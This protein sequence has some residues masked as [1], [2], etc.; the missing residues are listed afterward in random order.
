MM[1]PAKD[2]EE[3]L[4]GVIRWEQYSPEHKCEL[5]SH[6]V[7]HER[8]LWIFDP[9]PLAPLRVR[10]LLLRSNRLRIL[11]TN[12]NH[13]RDTVAWMKLPATLQP[14]ADRPTVTFGPWKPIPL[15]GGAPGETAFFLEEASLLVLGDAVVNLPKRKL[16]ILPDKYCTDPALLRS[17]LRGLCSLKFENLL[18]AHGSPVIGGAWK[19]VEALLR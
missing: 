7:L 13:L 18:L 4:P 5:T 14:G 12:E 11:R 10:D 2:F 19:K 15:P 1:T 3:I 8:N 17:E 16:E 6:A 9:I